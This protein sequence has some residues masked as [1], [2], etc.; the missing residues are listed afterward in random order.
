[1]NMKIAL[2]GS[3]KA[4]QGFEIAG[5]NKKDGTVYTFEHDCDIERLKEAFYTLI[6]KNDVGLIFIAENL[7][8]LL[9]NEINEYK[10]TLPAILKIPSRF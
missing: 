1:M 2:I 4:A 9:K 5:L 10:K 6:N 7:S 8:E 3:E